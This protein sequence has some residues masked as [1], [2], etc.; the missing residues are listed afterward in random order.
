MNPFS[1]FFKSSKN[2]TGDVQAAIKRLKDVQDTLQKKS[3]F[4]ESKIEEQ[5]II[6]KKCGTKKKRRTYLLKLMF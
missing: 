1:K 2:D 5:L 3:E 4:L 6:A